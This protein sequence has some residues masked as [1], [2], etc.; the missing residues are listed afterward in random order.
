MNNNLVSVDWLK[1]HLKDEG[2][3]VLDATLPKVSDKDKPL[4]TDGIPN[5]LKFD[6]QQTFLDKNSGLPNTVPH[7][8]DFEKNV[9]ALGI[10]CQSTIVI[11]DQHGVYSSPRAWWLFK[12]FGHKN[13][14]VLNGGLPEW[15]KHGFE[16]SNTHKRPS[17]I[18]SFTSTFKPQLLV[19]K[20][21]VFNNIKL[22]KYLVIDARSSKR[23]NAEV[24]EPRE[25]MSSGHIPKSKNL[26]YGSLIKNNLL[27]NKGELKEKFE[28]ITSENKIII[29]SCGSGIT[30]CILALAGTQVGLNHFSIYDGSWSEWGSDY[31][32][33]IEK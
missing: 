19:S 28:H 33:P 23:F 4:R 32:L 9:R 31:K 27:L 15:E 17:K 2:L 26:Y 11:Y 1:N 16:L 18:G 5:A 29:Y 21:D 10:D 14:F 3:V 20:N 25:G 30:A 13:V 6:L 12:F 8:K 22:Q 24:E 7:A